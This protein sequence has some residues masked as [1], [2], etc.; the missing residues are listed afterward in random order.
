MTA[1]TI[2]GK[3]TYAYSVLKNAISST[4]KEANLGVYLHE[5]HNT[6]D[7]L[8]RGISKI[9][10]VS[11]NQKIHNITDE[12]IHNYVDKVV[13]RLL[14][15]EDFGSLLRIIVPVNNACSSLH[16]LIYA[17]KLSTQL[18]SIVTAI[19]YVDNATEQHRTH[20]QITVDTVDSYQNGTTEFAKNLYLLRDDNNLLPVQPKFIARNPSQ[21][22]T[23]MANA[24]K[25]NL[26]ILSYDPRTELL[27]GLEIEQLTAIDCPIIIVPRNYSSS[28]ISNILYYTNNTHSQIGDITVKNI[29]GLEFVN[30]NIQLTT[31]STLHKPVLSNENLTVLKKHC[32][33]TEVDLITVPKLSH[34]SDLI[35]LLR[36]LRRPV[37]L[38]KKN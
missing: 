26:V 24:R 34:T 22:I 23:N 19:N 8:S 31:L 7:I 18:N 38:M 21:L 4:I 16:G 32:D 13:L 27:D 25:N 37:M 14:E 15:Q 30:K 17:K 3:P 10:A 29:T 5:N 20:S 11:I 12:A 35:V 9:P 36:E 28:C 6:S 33:E 1:L 2:Y